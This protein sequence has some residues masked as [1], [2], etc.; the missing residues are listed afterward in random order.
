MSMEPGSRTYWE[1]EG[2]HQDQDPKTEALASLLARDERLWGGPFRNELGNET[3]API[4]P[5]TDHD[6]RA[7]QTR[8][9]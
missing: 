7:N 3:E 1:L 6:S 4:P 2:D 5:S 9:L 8:R